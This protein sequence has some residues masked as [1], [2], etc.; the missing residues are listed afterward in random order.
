MNHDLTDVFSILKKEYRSTF[1]FFHLDNRIVASFLYY[2]AHNEYFT[3]T[4][5]VYYHNTYFKNL[6]TG[7]TSRAFTEGKLYFFPTGEAEQIKPREPKIGFSLG[8]TLKCIRVT[9]N[10]L[11]I[12]EVQ[13]GQP[14]L[15]DIV[16][17]YYDNAAV[18]EISKN[19]LSIS[20]IDYIEDH[21]KRLGIKPD[22]RIIVSNFLNN[23]VDYTLEVEE[24]GEVVRK[25]NFNT[26]VDTNGK[27]FGTFYARFH[28]IMS[29][30]KDFVPE[31]QQFGTK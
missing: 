19:G 9:E 22:R 21:I 7:I 17:D 26:Y 20:N 30:N 4:D 25:E 15:A 13:R 23:H 28:E 5:E 16:V 29:E 3:G 10:G 6:D 31:S 27:D 2:N 18:E 11:F 1:D 8:K 24:N 14:D 12:E